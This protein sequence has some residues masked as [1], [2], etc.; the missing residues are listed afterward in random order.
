VRNPLFYAGTLTPA[1]Y[2]GWLRDNAVRYVAISAAS[3]DRAAAA[4]A[5]IVRAGQ[6]W[7]VP[8]WRNA[9]WTLY[10][11]ADATPLA[12]PPAMV[13]NTT[14]RRWP[15]RTWWAPPA[16]HQYWK[17]IAVPRRGGLRGRPVRC[18]GVLAAPAGA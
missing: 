9:F 7:L 13:I 8:V 1:A 17:V 2:Y 16:D 10:L 3:P 5:R 14:P 4:E 11:V 12:S 18:T 15:S 6:P